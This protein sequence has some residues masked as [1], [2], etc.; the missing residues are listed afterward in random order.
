MDEK[1][2]KAKD[3]ATHYDVNIQTVWKWVREGRI[4]AYKIGKGRNYRFK[5]SELPKEIR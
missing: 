1:W 2:V 5:L 3:V 4:P